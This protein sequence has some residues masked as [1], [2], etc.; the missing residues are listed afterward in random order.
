[1]AL[2]S[3][4]LDAFLFT[5]TIMI[6]AWAYLTRRL[7]P[8]HSNL[9]TPYASFHA[10]L[11]I[12]VLLHTLCI[13]CILLVKTPPNIFTRLHIPLTMSSDKIRTELLKHASVDSVP[14]GLPKHLETLLKR[15]SSFDARNI[16]VR[17]C[18]ISS[19]DRIFVALTNPAYMPF[20]FGQSVLQDC[21]YCHAYDEYALYALP[22]PLLE[23][24]RET[25]VVGI[26]TISGSYK[27]RWRTLAIGAIVCAAVAEGYWVSTVRIQIPK[28]GM[29]VVMVRDAD[30]FDCRTSS[31]VGCSGMMSYG[32]T[33]IS[34]SSSFR[35]Y[36]ASSRPSLQPPI[37]W[38]PYHQR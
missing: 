36:F 20:R 22:R 17:F 4:S 6:S 9:E 37:R 34:S 5:S 3:A 10:W 35:S 7:H 13:L 18:L 33:D 24:I 2:V 12:F 29:G 19:S 1:M 27:E 38:H 21:E 32:L 14:A 11:N 31:Y 23:Y 25:A 8:F 16:Y 15:L 26:L 28:D 30:D